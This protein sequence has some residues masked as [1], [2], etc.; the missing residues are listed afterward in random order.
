MKEERIIEAT[1]RHFSRDPGGD[2]MGLSQSKEGA[3]STAFLRSTH[4]GANLERITEIERPGLA[5]RT[6][7]KIGERM[8][9]KVPT[10]IG[11]ASCR[12]RV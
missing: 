8:F 11:R 7:Y 5:I 9:G 4:T 10:Q 1:Y 3:V 6:F 12:E 2:T